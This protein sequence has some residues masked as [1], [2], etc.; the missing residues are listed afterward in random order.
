MVSVRHSLVWPDT[1]TPE[2]GT[3]VEIMGELEPQVNSHGNKRENWEK[4]GEGKAC[5]P[6]ETQSN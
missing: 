6:F 4:P 3:F 1:E 2:L 5:M